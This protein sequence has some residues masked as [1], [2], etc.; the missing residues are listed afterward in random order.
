M[1]QEIF[2]IYLNTEVIAINQDPLGIQGKKIKVFPSEITNRVLF[3][4][5]S[6]NDPMKQTQQWITNQVNLKNIQRQSTRFKV[7]TVWSLNE[8][9][10]AIHVIR[11]IRTKMLQT[12]FLIISQKHEETRLAHEFLEMNQSTQWNQGYSVSHRQT[13]QLLQK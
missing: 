9:H 1:S 2:N 8:K 5:C 12:P 13:K 11:T 4:R 7:I 6:S 3:T 10:T